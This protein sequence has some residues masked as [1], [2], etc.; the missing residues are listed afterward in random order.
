[1]C[2]RL[3]GGPLV[4]LLAA[5]AFVLAALPFC[6]RYHV[7]ETVDIPQTEAIQ[8]VRNLKIGWNLGGALDAC[9]PDVYGLDTETCWEEPR[10]TPEMLRLV[11]DAGYRTVRIP[12]TWGN[13]M[14]PGPDYI[15]A[16][17]WMDRVQEVVDYAYDIGLYVI[18][19]THNEDRTWHI[20]DRKHEEAVS[21][22]MAELWSQVAERFKNYD[23]RLLFESMNE[24][25]VPGSLLEWAGGTFSSRR[26]LNRLNDEFVWLIR[27]SGGNNASR[28]L[29]IPTHAAARDWIA[30]KGMKVPDDERV[31][32]SIHAYYPRG[33]SGI[34]YEERTWGSK[35]DYR[36]ME[37]MLYGIYR[38]FVRKGVSV[39][40]GEFGA[41]NK[42]NL[43]DRLA[44]TDFYVRTA[45]KFGM[46]CCWWDG[47]KLD[48][49]EKNG[50]YYGL[51][52]R[53]EMRWGFP[54]LVE[55]MVKAA[56]ND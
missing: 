32:V 23:E 41:V 45:R 46:P 13:H 53:N 15:V 27:A 18:L 47:G 10:T 7:P 29:V 42:H 3:T 49:E 24:P 11:K 44:Y 8:F 1:M 33:F 22:Q 48:G 31:I 56:Q 50:Y 5:L 43:E 39:L 16:S 51:M 30:R 37:R 26:I 25:R 28:Y 21:A 35:S 14:G 2:K 40:L 54:N 34:E 19:N 55:A 9:L 6:L 4:L 12:V 52:D 17:E 38:D 36:K 20:P